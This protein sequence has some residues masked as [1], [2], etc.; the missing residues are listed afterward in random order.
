MANF[1][2]YQLKELRLRAYLY[3]EEHAGS[4]NI[5]NQN[6]DLFRVALER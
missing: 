3:A 6:R 2:N 5:L 1:S 4:Q